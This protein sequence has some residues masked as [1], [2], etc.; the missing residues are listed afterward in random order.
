RLNGGGSLLPPYVSLDE[1]TSDPFEYEK[2]HYAG[3]AHAP[4]RP[5]GPSLDDMAP[6]KSLER[7]DDRKHLLAAFDAMRRELDR[8]DAFR[9]LDQF[10]ARALE[11]ITS[12]A[13]R[14]AFDLSK[15]SAETLARYGK[16]K[17]P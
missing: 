1:A 3:A 2:P 10:Q 7:L 16:G 5:F 11:I 6:V 8:Q 4:F 9:G 17:Y 12:P 15:E 13:V 14:D